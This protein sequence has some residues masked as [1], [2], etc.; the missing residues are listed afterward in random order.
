VWSSIIRVPI[1]FPPQRFKNGT[2]LAGMC[3]PDLQ[4]TQGSFSF[5]STKARKDKHIGGQ[6]YQIR[7][8]NGVVESKLTGPPGGDGHPMKCPVKATFDATSKR[9]TLEAGGEKATVSVR[10]YTP[11]MAIPFDNCTGIARFYVQTWEGNDVEIYVTPI[12]IDPNSPAMPI[13]H[14]FVY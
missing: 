11:W 6:Q 13:S 9:I 1:T 3:V 5:Y 14:P 10:E 7:F 8:K 4:G 12:N 2:L